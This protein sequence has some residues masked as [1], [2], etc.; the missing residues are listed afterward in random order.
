MRV[1]VFQAFTETDGFYF[2]L[3]NKDKNVL[4]KKERGINFMS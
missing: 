4:A 1:V 3:K 2:Q